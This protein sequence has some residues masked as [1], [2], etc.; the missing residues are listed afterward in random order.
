MNHEGYI[1]KD[2][3]SMHRCVKIYSSI[4]ELRLCCGEVEQN[5]ID[6]VR[7]EVIEED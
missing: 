2:D 6:H 1:F 3:I 7:W 5:Q 4:Q